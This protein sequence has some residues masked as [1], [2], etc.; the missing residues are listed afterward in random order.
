MLMC[1]QTVRDVLSMPADTRVQM[2]VLENVRP[3]TGENLVT[4]VS[5]QE[6][7]K[8]TDKG[9]IMLAVRYESGYDYLH[10]VMPMMYRDK[11]VMQRR[12]R[13][14]VG[15]EVISNMNNRASLAQLR[16]KYVL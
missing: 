4:D 3:L 6:T 12:I 13:T 7:D 2:L 11:L 10:I 16:G 15:L 9:I 14:F 1:L 5:I 8:D